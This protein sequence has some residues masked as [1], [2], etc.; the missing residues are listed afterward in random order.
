M[1]VLLGESRTPPLK[2]LFIFFS[3]SE[4]SVAKKKLN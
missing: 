1:I 4:I 2:H 3:Q